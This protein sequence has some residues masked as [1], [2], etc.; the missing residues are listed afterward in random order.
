MGMLGIKSSD[1]DYPQFQDDWYDSTILGS[2]NNTSSEFITD[3][4]AYN[5]MC[6][7]IE[8]SPPP[9]PIPSEI[10]DKILEQYE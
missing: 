8:E 9:K 7:L 1:L 4:D 6:R 10:L 2:D 5:L 3:M